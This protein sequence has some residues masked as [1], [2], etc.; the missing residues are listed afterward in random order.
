[1]TPLPWHADE[2]ASLVDAKSRLPHAVLLHGPRGIGKLA[3]ARAMAQALL[4]EKPLA[5]GGACGQCSGCGWFEGGQHPD[6]R[7]VEPAAVTESGSEEADKKS[8]IISVQ[9]IRALTDFVNMT[10]HRGGLKVI[11]IQ[12]ADALNANAANALLKVLEEPPPLT[13]FLLVAH[14]T[15]L[16]PATLRSRCRHI[17][18]TA[19]SAAAAAA[20]LGEQGVEQRDLALAMTGNAPL[21]ALELDSSGYWSARAALLRQLSRDEFDPMAAAEAL[22]D[23]PIVQVLDWLQKWSYDLV[24]ARVLNRVRY[25]I[26]CADVISRTARRVDALAALRFHRNV[27]NLQPFAY[28]PLNQ[29]LSCESLLL[30]YRNLLGTGAVVSP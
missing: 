26:D 2:F 12:P 11:V 1:M 16:L 3:F 13:C 6:Y 22:R 24:C 30:D 21:L 10:S 18:L 27:V 8:T 23:C 17:A 9:Q 25:N 7:Q 28:H 5:Q 15:H 29:R 19:P 4:C 20:W 14:R